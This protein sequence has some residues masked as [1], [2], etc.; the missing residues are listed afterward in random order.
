MPAILKDASEFERAILEDGEIGAAEHERAQLAFL[1]CLERAGVEVV[2]FDTDENGLV[3]SAS[4]VLGEDA[5]ADIPLNRCV[6]SF[7]RFVPEASRIALTP[8]DSNA[9][10]AQ[11]MADCMIARGYDVPAGPVDFHAVSQE[12]EGMEARLAFDECFA[13]VEFAP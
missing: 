13:E 1:D 6:E 7:Y 2:E 5:G 11:R 12:I 8:N 9:T 10:M 4:Y 3:R